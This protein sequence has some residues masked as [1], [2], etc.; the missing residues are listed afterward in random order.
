MEK[1][2]PL[3]KNLTKALTFA[4]CCVLCMGVLSI[5]TY[6]LLDE[7]GWSVN[8]AT[9]VFEASRDMLNEL[10]DIYHYYQIGQP[11]TTG[12]SIEPLRQP[13]FDYYGG[14]VYE[15]VPSTPNASY[16]IFGKPP[17]EY[18]ISKVYITYEGFTGIQ[19]VN[20]E[21]GGNVLNPEFVFN[22][23]V[24]VGAEII[25][26]WKYD[27]THTTNPTYRFNITFL[28]DY[29]PPNDDMTLEEAFKKGYQEGLKD[30][31]VDGNFLS[32]ITDPI[33]ALFSITI[34][35]IDDTVISLGTVFFTVVGIS[36]MLWFLKYFAGG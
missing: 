20:P 12:Y 22:A 30:G 34:I 2:K 11:T 1:R 19:I 9:F 5:P 16:T 31:R 33:G 6:A 27:I 24:A 3:V 4:L 8:G 32:I 28:P 10:D 15:I 26:E 21:V 36:L 14:R 18:T 13:D 29:E 35:E 17:K 25:I 7:N 23:N